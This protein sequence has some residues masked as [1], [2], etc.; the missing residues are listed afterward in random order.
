MSNSERMQEILDK[1]EEGVRTFFSSDKYKQYLDVMSRFHSYSL[2]NQI[3][4]ATQRPEATY[5][6]GFNAWNRNFDRRVKKGE[7]AI[8][9]LAPQKVKVDVKTGE[10]GING[11]PVTEK[12]ERLIFRPVPVFDISQTEGKELPELIN[13]LT[14][15]VEN[16]NEFMMAAAV[17]APFH[18]SIQEL[19]TEAKGWCDYVSENIVIKAGMSELH[20][21][22]TALHETAHARIHT[23]AEAKTKSRQ[24]REVEAESIAY[25]VCR[26]FGLDTSEYSFG[27]VAAWA[28][29]QETEVLRESLETIRREAGEMI[30]IIEG[31][32]QDKNRGING[33]TPAEM[34][35][36][37]KE[38]VS[39]A[40]FDT[41]AQAEVINARV[42]G[43]Y[44]LP[45]EPRKVNV[46][47]EYSGQERED[48][49]FNLVHEKKV[50]VNGLQLDI[51]PIKAEKSGTTEQ[52]YREVKKYDR[53]EMEDDS[54]PM[55]MVTYSSYPKIRTGMRVNI[56]EASRII[57]EAEKQ[58][59]KDEIRGN[60]LRVNIS[61]TYNGRKEERTDAVL[62]GEG[63]NNFID[64]MSLP[65]EVI[66]YMHRH[67]QI[68]DVVE[69][70]KSA[71]SAKSRAGAMYEDMML[72]W[73]E[74]A[75]R[76]LNYNTQAWVLCSLCKHNA[77][78][79]PCWGEPQAPS[80]AEI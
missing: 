53:A 55:I 42:Y 10:T 34:E 36:A 71:V 4:I 62:L 11:E 12:K 16:Y 44:R 30:E 68:L 3:L 43:S 29:E 78:K 2:N 21:V 64:Y 31:V 72:E 77:I 28:G 7:R 61:Y 70:A 6:A 40:L 25:T 24:Q 79:P 27:Y 69:Q 65:P 47:V 57:A 14:G 46:M 37:A 74:E 32:L 20:T 1:L 73:S 39:E 49:I 33:V 5:I 66:T 56:H 26:H 9:I 45:G 80:E 41:A 35:A 19:T 22:K 51:N 23:P 15:T 63:R 67:V 18:I 38:A 50:T 59:G 54:W 13:E 17:A 48:H 52:Y 75:R 76:E 60:F 58:L 8:Y